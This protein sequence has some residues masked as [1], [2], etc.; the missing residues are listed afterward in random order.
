MIQIWRSSI[1]SCEFKHITQP[2]SPLG[3]PMNL[4]DSRKD[5]MPQEGVKLKSEHFAYF[6][7]NCPTFT[8][9]LA[10]SNKFRILLWGG[11]AVLTEQKQCNPFGRSFLCKTQRMVCI[12]MVHTWPARL[13]DGLDPL[14]P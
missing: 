11:E 7:A 9:L 3:L 12:S 8:Y 5:L 1:L 13:C 2:L 14:I 6:L 4:I 10:W